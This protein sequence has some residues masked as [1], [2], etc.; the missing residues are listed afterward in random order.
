MRIIL[1]FICLLV[2]TFCSCQKVI[3]VNLGS[4]PPAYVVV[5][6]I[7]D[8][9][10]PYTVTITKS[11]NFD[12]DNVFP[13]VHGATVYITDVTAGLTDTLSEF[14]TGMYQTHILTGTPGH[15][16]KM[17]IITSNQNFTATSTM[18]QPVALDSV[19]TQTS[20]FGGDTDVVPMYK[21]PVGLGNFYHLLLTIEDS[22]ST[23]IYLH[24]DEI[25]DGEEVKQPLRNN[26][27]VLPGN[28]ITVELQCIDSGVYQYY[29]NLQQTEQ[30]NSATPANPQS[31]V[32]GGALGYFSAHTVRKKSITVH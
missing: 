9:P 31:N 1:S 22:V 18:P 5:G 14:V 19:Y 12:Q 29:N 24:N 15:V 30:Q 13:G 8:Q 27:K 7:T 25:S 23:E 6:N 4:T 20:I 11:V 21:D 17:N 10:G 2:I 26:I 3:N 16:Y 32:K 28:T